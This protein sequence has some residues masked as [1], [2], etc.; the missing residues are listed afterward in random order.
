MIRGLAD[1]SD[2]V[3]GAAALSVLRL[4]LLTAFAVAGFNK[5]SAPRKTRQSMAR[6]GVP[7]QLTGLVTT[8]LPLAEL[9]VAL[10]LAY[11]VTVYVSAITALAL[12]SIFTIAICVNLAL[13]R[14][15]DC[16]CFGSFQ[17]AAI[18]LCSVGRNLVLVLTCVG[19]LVG[20]PSHSFSRIA[21]PEVSWPI[22]VLWT[23]G[24]GVIAC[25]VVGWLR[26]GARRRT[27]PMPPVR[28]K[29][30]Q[31]GA[32]MPSFSIRLLNGAVVTR[33]WLSRGGRSVLMVFTHP[34][35]KQCVEILSRLAR[36]QKDHEERMS[37]TVFVLGD[38]DASRRFI[39]E[40]LINLA[41]ADEEARV[42]R[43]F[44]V[45]GVPSAILIR[46]DGTVAREAAV[47]TAA[48]L[49]LVTQVEVDFS[50]ASAVGEIVRFTEED[51]CGKMAGL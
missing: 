5:L 15:P 33:E 37:T 45:A 26:F 47:G 41:A 32:S 11:P 12:L 9:S 10:G 6:F 46:P 17:P 22:E 19:L 34:A 30:V 51:A 21:R 40:H 28:P 42:T 29:G 25:T 3:A 24:L 2:T 31:A 27:S 50:A 48:V 39:G 36:L 38:A 1:I 4:G 16:A 49:N 7:K 18:S 14:K 20:G 8:L 35:C 23:L 43:L 44:G 13:G